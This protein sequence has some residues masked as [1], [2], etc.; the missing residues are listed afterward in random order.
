MAE[1]E[2][3]LSP[4]AWEGRR[5][6]FSEFHLPPSEG[7]SL[8]HQRTRRST[9]K[10]VIVLGVLLGVAGPGGPALAQT[11][12]SPEAIAAQM[13]AQA[14]PA[15]DELVKL[16]QSKS[17]LSE[18]EAAL[19]SHAPLEPQTKQVLAEMLLSKHLINR[20]EYDRT[21][22]SCSAPAKAASQ[23][24]TPSIL[25]SNGN[26]EPGGFKSFSDWISSILPG[27]GQTSDL[28]FGTIQPSPLWPP[29]QEPQTKHKSRK[30][31]RQDASQAAPGPEERAP[32]Q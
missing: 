1:P 25:G 21:L 30:H 6:A 17:I 23:R 2:Y 7:T 26:G 28:D 27:G 4:K 18:T 24:A 5:L 11:L 31:H 10:E 3:D 15:P 29:G 16:L 22:E 19:A 13:R 9:M 32:K 12:K 20:K 8:R 14:K